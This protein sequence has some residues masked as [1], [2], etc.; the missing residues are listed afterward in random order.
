MNAIGLVAKRLKYYMHREQ[1]RKERYLSKQ[2]TAKLLPFSLACIN[3]D[4]P[5]NVGYC[6]RAVACY[7][8]SCLH[9]IGKL[10]EYHDLMRF[11]GGV[12]NF[13][14]VNQHSNPSDL[15]E[16]ARNR[17]IHMVACELT[18]NAVSIHDWEMPDV[19]M[20]V[21]VGNERIGV[22]TEILHRAQSVVYIPMVGTGFSLNTSQTANV[23]LYELSKRYLN[24]EGLNA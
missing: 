2:G 21:V 24:K 20:I 13:I 1:T 23:V 10:P 18:D 22:P 5:G 9:V 19:P 4:E 14:Q 15:I 6:A 7:G 3:L 11:S 12:S 17:D 8:A 16:Y